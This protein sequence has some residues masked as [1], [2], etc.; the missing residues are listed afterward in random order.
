MPGIGLRFIAILLVAAIPSQHSVAASD[1]DGTARAPVVETQKTTSHKT[2]IGGR[3]LSYQATA[4]TL[5]IRDDEGRATASMFYVAYVAPEEKGGKKRPITFLF[6]GGPGSASLWLNVGGLGPMY[7]VTD[8]PRATGPAPYTFIPSPHSLLDKTDLVF[9]DAVGTGY[10]RTLGEAKGSDF[11]GVDADVD[12]FARAIVRYVSVNQRWGA[13]KFL[14]GE[15]Y[16]TTRASALV[17]KLQNQGMQFNGVVLLASI[18]NF[19]VAQ[20]GLDQDYINSLPS[21]A[22]TAWYHGKIAD[23]PADLLAFL[24]EVREFAQGAYGTALAKGDRITAAQEEAVAAQLSRYVGLPADYLRR[25]RLRIDMEA[26]R[27]ELLR[28]RGLV[29]GRFDSRFTAPAAYVATSGAFDPATNDPATAGVT[30]AYLSSYRDH[31]SGDL[32]YVSDLAYRPLYNMVISAAWNW[33]HKAPGFDAPLHT[34]NVA[35]DLA[36][37]LRSNP[38]LKVLS[39][40]GLFDLATPFFGTEFDLSHMLLSPDLQRNLTFSYYESGHMTY[41]DRLALARMKADLARFYD[42]TLR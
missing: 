41:G 29:T 31:L 26:F 27:V 38:Q 24:Q 4:G 2:T 25:A 42:E 21:F 33:R 35:L 34:P 32:G 19:A 18:L 28:D 22:A 9:L 37:A 3:T 12:A 16:G 15:S 14:F 6:N 40:N 13:P 8:A 39:M 17:Y 11:W 36:A 23:K 5:T 1:E 7:A 30:S 20:P 10:S